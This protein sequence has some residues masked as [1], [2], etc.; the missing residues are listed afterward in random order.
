LS[1]TGL[2]EQFNTLTLTINVVTEM[3]SAREEAHA[4]HL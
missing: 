1:I 3:V 2:R 4:E